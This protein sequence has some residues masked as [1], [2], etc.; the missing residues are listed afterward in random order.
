MMNPVRLEIVQDDPVSAP[1]LSRVL[2]ALLYNV[3]SESSY[4]DF[5][6]KIDSLLCIA[7]V[8]YKCRANRLLWWNLG[9]LFCW[10]LILTMYVLSSLA[11]KYYTLIAIIVIMICIIY[12]VTI[13]IWMN[14]PTGAAPATETMKEIRAECEAMTNRTPHASFHI[15]LTPFATS[16]RAHHLYTNPILFIE[17]SVSVVGFEI[18]RMKAGLPSIAAKNNSGSNTNSVPPPA[19]HTTSTVTNDYQ[20]LDIVGIQA[21]PK[22]RLIIIHRHIGILDTMTQTNCGSGMQSVEAT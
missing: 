12:L 14:C 17:V 1:R 3:V 19:L 8:D 10:I 7:A 11:G 5:C 16:L 21:R 13:R 18:A 15:V 2:P 22:D 4:F 20:Q 6:D 9:M